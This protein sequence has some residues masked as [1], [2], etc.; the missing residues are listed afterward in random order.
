MRHNKK[1]PYE[2]PLSECPATCG[3][4]KFF[5]GIIMCK[6]NNCMAPTHKESNPKD[7]PLA[8]PL[9]CPWWYANH[10][11]TK[12]TANQRREL[13]EKRRHWFV[14]HK[15]LAMCKSP[16]ERLQISKHFDRDGGKHL[17]DFRVYP[18]AKELHNKFMEEE[19]WK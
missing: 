10:T 3:D 12:V 9:S 6:A 11:V 5:S 7:R 16:S 1:S 14:L 4:C 17:F 19:K 18:V 2:R 13:R 15:M 8:M